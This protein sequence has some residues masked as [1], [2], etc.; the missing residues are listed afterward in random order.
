MT[1][2]TGPTVTLLVS[3]TAL[4]LWSRNGSFRNYMKL[5]Q[6]LVKPYLRLFLRSVACSA[7][8]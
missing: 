2:S 6:I 3:V 1:R 8:T 5:L 4:C 7:Y